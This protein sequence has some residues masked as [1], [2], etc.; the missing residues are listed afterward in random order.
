MTVHVFDPTGIESA[1]ATASSR[2]ASTR[3]LAARNLARR[4]N[5]LHL[6][7]HTGGRVEFSNGPRRA[8]AG[9]FRESTSYYV[10][11]IEPDPRST[12]RYNDITGAPT[13][14]ATLRSESAVRPSASAI[15]I[16]AVT[17]RPRVSS[18]S[19]SR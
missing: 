11:G 14:A 6:P 16:A 7:D 15:S 10:L 3:A 2:T 8:V 19:R 17:I 5:L 4:N 13:L 1:S 18:I 9:M 12:R